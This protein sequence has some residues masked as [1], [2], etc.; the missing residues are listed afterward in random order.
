MRTSPLDALSRP[1]RAIAWAIVFGESGGVLVGESPHDKGVSVH[2]DVR[3]DSVPSLSWVYRD[4]R[5]HYTACSKSYPVM[6]I[7]V[8]FTSMS[9]TFLVDFTRGDFSSTGQFLQ[10]LQVQFLQ[11]FSKRHASSENV[12]RTSERG[13][14]WPREM[15]TSPLDALLRP[16]RAMAWAIVFGES[17]GVLVGE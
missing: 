14:K 17:G 10:V 8:I 12:V 9:T 7:P 4:Q 15:R 11:V 6:N 1:Q 2:P 5:S 3:L 16:Q 13:R